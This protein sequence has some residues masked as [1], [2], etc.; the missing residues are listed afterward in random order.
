MSAYRSPVAQLW[1]VRLLTFT[2]TV[3]SAPLSPK[4]DL[5]RTGPLLDP[6][7]WRVCLLSKNDVNSCR[8]RFR[9]GVITENDL[10]RILERTDERD[11]DSELDGFAF[12]I[13]RVYTPKQ[14]DGGLIPI[15]CSDCE[16]LPKIRRRLEFKHQPCNRITPLSNQRAA[17]S[18][19]T[20]SCAP[21]RISPRYCSVSV[22]DD[23]GT[24]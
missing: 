17:F 16:T 6:T 12:R 11:Q 3:D 9:L 14:T 20:T 15:D 5:Q 4:I 7:L 22:Q 23:A 19:L 2:R 13:G 18:F 10:V 8:G 24:V 21:L 1:S